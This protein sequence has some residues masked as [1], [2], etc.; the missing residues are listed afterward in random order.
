[1][2]NLDSEPTKDSGPP[3]SMERRKFDSE[4]DAVAFAKSQ[5]RNWHRVDVYHAGQG[6][7]LVHFKDGRMYIGNHRI[8]LE[9]DE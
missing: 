1:M 6:R 4:D 7:P 5:R 9:Y 8:R 3:K 2:Y